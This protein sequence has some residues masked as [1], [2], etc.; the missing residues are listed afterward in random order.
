MQMTP[1][2]S[3]AVLAS[4]SNG[5]A[6]YVETPRTRVLID[7]GVSARQV[8]LRLRKLRRDVR[9]LDAVFVTHDHMDHVSGVRVLARRFNLPVFLNRATLDAAHR[10][11]RGV[12]NP[13]VIRAGE[14]FDFQGITIRTVPVPHDSAEAMCYVLEFSGISLGVFTD[15]GVATRE[16]RT[17]VSQLDGLVLETNYDPE[18]LRIGRYPRELKRR[19]R[20]NQGHLSNV[21]A[22][23]LCRDCASSRLQVLYCAHL[24]AENN[25]P[26]LV[27]RTLHQTLASRRDLD[28]VRLLLTS[29]R[30]VS[31][32]TTLTPSPV[33]I[34]P[35]PLSDDSQVVSAVDF[36]DK[37]PPFPNQG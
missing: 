19:I 28:H 34:G 9:E 10:S 5:N 6:V 25:H 15:L 21:Q 14:E 7:S 18:K 12:K 33:A 2:L 37:A 3:T 36:G 32:L 17:A 26:D 24:S 1:T 30:T 13:E 23:E 20:G 8:E 11:L 4:G 29:R 22:A 31:A 27:L 16:V 35:G